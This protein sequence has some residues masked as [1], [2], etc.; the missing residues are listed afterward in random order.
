MRFICSIRSQ[1][2]FI[3]SAS[4]VVVSCL[5]G[6][7]QAR[8]ASPEKPAAVTAPIINGVWKLNGAASAPGGD[9][10]GGQGGRSSGG[11]SGSGGGSR[12]GGFGGRGGAG[13]GSRGG[14]SFEQAQKLHALVIEV[15]T[16]PDRLTVN[17][18]ETEVTLTYDS[19]QVLRYST[20]GK[21]EKHD[22]T[23]G[24]AKV[25]TTWAGG[26]LAQHIDLGS[27]LKLVGTYAVS[28]D[29]LVVRFV[30]DTGASASTAA[31]A[32]RD[33]PERRWVYD[34]VK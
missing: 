6:G 2:V 9:L 32:D 4:I 30:R 19:G 12:G 21:E 24:S 5:G 31:A 22:F 34:A 17:L 8:Q 3:L 33:A 18:D 14:G 11:R 29:Q 13:G 28:G 23:V 26:A 10:G 16:M 1:V 20:S 27:A 7:L 25:K 15:T